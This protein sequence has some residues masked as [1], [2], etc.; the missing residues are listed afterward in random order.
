MR[1]NSELRVRAAD[2]PP[3]LLCVILDASASGWSRLG[4]GD[5]EAGATALGYVAEQL[6]TFLSAFKLLHEQNTLSVTIIDSSGAHVICSPDDS[7]DYLQPRLVEALYNVSSK[8]GSAG[9]HMASALAGSLC[10]I[11]RARIA[12]AAAARTG[13]TDDNSSL[14]VVSLSAA[15]SAT[16]QARVLVVLVDRDSPREYVP[17][18]NCIFSAQRLRVPIDACVLSGED[19]TYFQQATYIT[20]GVYMR[21]PGF[22]PRVDDSLLETLLTIFLVDQLSRDFLAMPSQGTV[23]FRAS[24]FKTRKV[25]D[26]GYTCSVCLSTFDTSVGKKAAIC[27]ICG[28][29]FAVSKPVVKSKPPLR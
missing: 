26:I 10:V 3:S 19:S 4:G 8:S 22:D 27:P 14:P 23:D 13:S 1:Q 6:L 7:H 24:C 16:T 21:P 20:R 18:M 17:V 5:G 11:N 28:A 15:T 29:R 12:A 25:I 2:D 9:D